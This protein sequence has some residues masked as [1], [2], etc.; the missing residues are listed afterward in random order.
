MKLV[1]KKTFLNIYNHFP[2]ISKLGGR[3]A[4]IFNKT[5]AWIASTLNSSR[6]A[7][8]Y[9]IFPGANYIRNKPQGLGETIPWQFEL[10]YSGMIVNDPPAWVAELPD[11]RVVGNGAVIT[12]DNCL[13]VDVSRELIPDQ[14][15]HSI[16]NRIWLPHKRR[17]RA[18]V[19]VVSIASIN[20]WHWFFDLLPRVLLLKEYSDNFNNIDVIIVN[21]LTYYYQ[22]ET[23][24]KLGMPLDKILESDSN[25]HVQADFLIVPSVFK[26]IPSGWAC[27]KL[28]EKFTNNS[29]CNQQSLRLYIS[30]NDA[31]TR[32]ILNEEEVM[33]NLAQFGFKKVILTGMSVKEQRDLFHSA[34]F[35][36]APHGAGLTN[37]VFCR[38]GTGVLEIFPP[39]Y[40]NPCYWELSDNLGLDY[41][42]FLGE[43]ICP[44]PP[45]VDINVE[46]WFDSF[47]GTDEK[48]GRDIRVN[49]QDLLA[50]LTKALNTGADKNKFMINK[51]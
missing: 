35:I 28:H 40:V 6:N 44:S 34:E 39:T 7:N 38:K 16:F 21:K 12:P 22:W 4:G 5:E 48:Y 10:L 51:Q 30:R 47:I 8:I 23:L 31:Q 45:P 11:G 18:K 26:D 33:E 1:L 24:E 32:R 49:I 27:Q 42:Y 2:L 9:Q 20:Y 37:I 3:P 29:N 43:G 17:V 15:N 50:I 14:N 19:A 46:S 41:Y 25:L 36:V 13:L